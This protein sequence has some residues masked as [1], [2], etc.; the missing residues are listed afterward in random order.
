MLSIPVEAIRNATSRLCCFAVTCFPL[1]FVL[2]VDAEENSEVVTP[3]QTPP[4]IQV[5]VHSNQFYGPQTR[6]GSPRRSTGHSRSFCDVYL[7]D[8]P[9]PDSG[10]PTV[11]VIHGGGWASGDK[12]TLESYSRKLASSGIAAVTINYRLAPKHKFPAQADDVRQSMLW[13]NDRAEKYSFDLDRLGMCGY[14]AGGHLTLLISALADESIKDQVMAS[15]WDDD[16]ERWNRLP[17]L[18]AVCAGGPYC[19]FESLPIDNTTMSYFL[20]GSRREQEEIYRAASPLA[21]VSPSDPK[22]LI[23]HG[24]ADILV[25]IAGAREFFEKQRSL[26]VETSMKE[27]P[28]Q[29][30]VMTFLNPMTRDL[31]VKF[32][33]DELTTR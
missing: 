10:Y 17:K 33:Q 5:L 9:A 1:L 16:D 30:H 12:W 24:D 20:G 8:K 23:V 4:S 32:F 6:P 7:P 19:D 27:M 11:I 13:V 18:K 22:T 25:P 31:V 26:G 3:G 21:F 14:S 29:G 28:N 2:S 15:Q